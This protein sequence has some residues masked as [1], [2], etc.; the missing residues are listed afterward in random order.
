M[1]VND[2]P[3]PNRRPTH[4]R[5]ANSGRFCPSLTHPGFSPARE[6][7]ICLAWLRLYQAI[8]ANRS[9]TRRAESRPNEA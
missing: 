3:K 4:R 1:N 2:H 7:M 8:L 5:Q 6:F 9:E